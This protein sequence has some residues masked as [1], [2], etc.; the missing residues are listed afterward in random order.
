MASTDK[1]AEYDLPFIDLAYKYLP[2]ELK[3]SGKKMIMAWAKTGLIQRDRLIEFA[4]ANA[5]DGLY[6]VVSEEGRDH[7]DGTDTKTVTVN[8]RVSNY[9]RDNVKIGRAHV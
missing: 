9:S 4:M 1:A 3:G 8:Y 6:K 2:E 5:S 7:C